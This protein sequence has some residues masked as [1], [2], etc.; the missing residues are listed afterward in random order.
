[1]TGKPEDEGAQWLRA[2]FA[3]DRMAWQQELRASLVSA[4]VDL[5]ERNHPPKEEEILA[6]LLNVFS[7]LTSN[8]DLRDLVADFVERLPYEMNR[9]RRHNMKV[10]EQLQRQQEERRRAAGK[11]PPEE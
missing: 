11:P 4:L 9:R 6:H 8:A 3:A 7:G 10:W 1:M 5:S 2:A